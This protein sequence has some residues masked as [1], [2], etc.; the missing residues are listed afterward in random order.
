VRTIYNKNIKLECI[1][2][3]GG[4]EKKDEYPLFETVGIESVALEE[5]NLRHVVNRE[6]FHHRLE[7]KIHKIVFQKIGNGID[8]ELGDESRE[9]RSDDKNTRQ[10][11][12]AYGR[13]C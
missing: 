3:G 12:S 8:G 5:S 13:F 2:P 10:A 6:I 4:K 11:G 7:Q 1:D 9:Q